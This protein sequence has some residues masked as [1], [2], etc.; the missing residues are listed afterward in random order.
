[1]DKEIKELRD[2]INSKEEEV[3][4]LKAKLNRLITIKLK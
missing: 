4:I 1:M 3:A 2:K